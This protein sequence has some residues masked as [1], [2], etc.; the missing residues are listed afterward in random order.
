ML[1]VP[2]IAGLRVNDSW[3]E[4]F[5]AEAASWALVEEGVVDWPAQLRALEQ[6]G[7]EGFIVVETHLGDSRTAT[8]I[9]QHEV[10]PMSYGFKVP[11]ELIE[12]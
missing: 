9:D 8:G 7:Y 12:S 10:E 5:D 6:D 1:A 4:N 11:I 3:V 2:G